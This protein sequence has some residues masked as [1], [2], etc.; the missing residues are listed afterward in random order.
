MSRRRFGGNWGY[1]LPTWRN[2]SGRSPSFTPPTIPITGISG[3][4]AFPDHEIWI[5]GTSSSI[6][7]LEGRDWFFW[8][9]S[10]RGRVD[11]I[12]TYVDLNVYRGDWEQ[13]LKQFEE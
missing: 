2:T 6:H 3:R 9:Y 11:G 8:Q 5:R 10:N 12:G 7:N 1:P 4:D 13:F